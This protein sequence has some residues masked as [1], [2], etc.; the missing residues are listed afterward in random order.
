VSQEQL[1][2]L[3]ADPSISITAADR[4][5]P[6]VYS[7]RPIAV[8]RARVLAR[9]PDDRMAAAT[10]MLDGLVANG[11][12]TPVATR[13][14]GGVAVISVHD[15]DVLMILP[16]DV[17]PLSGE[18]VHSVAAHAVAQLGIALAE[19]LELRAP[20]RMI[21]NTM[22]ALAAAV[23]FGFV[24]WGL[25][26]AHGY[27]GGRL[28]TAAHKRVERLRGRDVVHAV[29][30][31]DP[32]H[33]VV[34]AG[35]L[36]IAAFCGYE[37]LTFTLRRFPYTRPWG[38]SLRE[39]LIAETTWVVRGFFAA[40]PGLVTILVIVFLARTVARMATLFFD[41]IESGRITVP[42]IY[43]DT[44]PPTR[45]LVSAGVWLFALAMSYPYLPGSGSDAFKGVSFFVGLIISLGSSGLVNQAMSGLTMR[46]SRALRVGDFVRIG[47]VEGTVMHIGA[48]SIKLKTAR[49]EEVTIPH[50]VLVSYMT[51]NYSREAE[52]ERVITATSVSIGYDAP[53]RQVHAMLL[54]AAARTAGIRTAP[55]PTVLQTALDDFSVSYTLCVC[56]EQPQ[57][58]VATLA[59]LYANIQDAFNEHGVQIMSPHYETDPRAPKIVPKAQWYAEPAVRTIQPRS[60]TS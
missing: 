9:A 43:A 40:L 49:R 24:L 8:L 2:K 13:D 48:L 25:R 30:L 28:T 20:A 31:L 55:A 56:L 54:Q 60:K 58:R 7:N 34:N 5:A 45:H 23:L 10:R 47:E 6:L 17:D 52:G 3:L 51:T 37:W 59:A 22:E 42:G 53:W 16:A 36:A 18:T 12:I 35:T 19:A 38:E 14:V 32:L 50:A 44:A 1:A 57:L 27:L 33:H 39:L 46:Y 29:H 26:R 41:A 4:P 21:R 11:T 15:K